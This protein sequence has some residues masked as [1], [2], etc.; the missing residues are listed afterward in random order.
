[1]KRN[2]RKLAYVGLTNNININRRDKQHLWNNTEKMTLFCVEKNIALPKYKILDKDLKSSDA[3]KRESYWINFYKNIDWE[4]FNVAKPG[5]LGGNTIKWTRKKLQSV[6]NEYNCRRDFEKNDNLAYAAAVRLKILDELF[7]NYP[8]NGFLKQKV[9][10]WSK[11]ILQIEANKYKFR[12]DFYKYSG[13]A[14]SKA[15]S[16]KMLD[17]LFENHLNEG[18]K[19]KKV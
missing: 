17:E 9:G 10:Y 12:S 11:Q 14:Y 16:F 3:Q 7:E 6:V 8:N 1:M 5:A 15:S 2:F 13:S 4:L 18:Y 19:I